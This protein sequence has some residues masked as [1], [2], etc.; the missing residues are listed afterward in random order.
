MGEEK[1][2]KPGRKPTGRKKFFKTFSVSCT[3]EQYE[4]IKD[5]AFREN[6]TVSKMF[7][8]YMLSLNEH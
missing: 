5:V 1:K 4:I 6:K 8:E 3:P 2:G 7:V